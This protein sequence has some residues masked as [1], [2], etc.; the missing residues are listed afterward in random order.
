LDTQSAIYSNPSLV[1]F[2][3]QTQTFFIWDALLCVLRF[4]ADPGFYSTS[5]V[6]RTWDKVVEVYS[7]HPELLKGR[8]TLYVTIGSVTLK[9][10]RVSPLPGPT[11]QPAFIT[12]LHA[13]REAVANKEPQ[14]NGAA[15]PDG[16]LDG[17]AAHDDFFN[18]S[19]SGLNIDGNFA[20]ESPD[21]EFWDQFQYVET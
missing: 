20:L 16:T 4:L 8:R 3:W 13:R 5:E 14:L 1:K 15:N 9:A 21:W 11:A 2:R 19:Y 12:A 6:T 18:N 17:L 7:N 10:W